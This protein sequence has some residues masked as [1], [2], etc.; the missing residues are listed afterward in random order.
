[1]TISDSDDITRVELKYR[2]NPADYE[3]LRARLRAI[4]EPDPHTAPLPWYTVRSVYF[5]NAEDD[6]LN[7]KVN[8][9][10]VRRLYRIR[11]YNGGSSPL[12]L[13]RKIK[14]GNLVSK[15]RQ[16]ITEKEYSRATAVGLRRG[17][18][19]GNAWTL[20]EKF[21]I[22]AGFAMLRPAILVEYKREAFVHPRLDVRVTFDTCLRAAPGSRPLFGEAVR[23][24]RLFPDDVIILEIKYRSFL[25][26]FISGMLSMS[27]RPRIAISKYMLCR[28][29]GPA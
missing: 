9:E 23:F 29:Y 11:A 14:T 21:S 19:S 2:I 3:I 12:Y 20:E 15:R 7:S 16:R 13:E 1:M 10:R 27:N 22:D 8:G 24:Q 25:P 6:V 5:D 17:P 18:G 28:S 4:M 26:D